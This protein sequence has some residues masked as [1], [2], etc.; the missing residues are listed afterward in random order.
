MAITVI[1]RPQLLTFIIYMTDIFLLQNSF[2]IH[3][4][5]RCILKKLKYKYYTEEG[6]ND[7][8]LTMV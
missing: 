2:K 3:A 5:L 6:N 1:F 7:V 8:E 4:I